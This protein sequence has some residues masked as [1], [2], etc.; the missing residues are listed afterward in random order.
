MQFLHFLGTRLHKI[1][2]LYNSIY[3]IHVLGNGYMDMCRK[4]W[5]IYYGIH[6]LGLYKWMM[7][8]EGVSVMKVA[9]P[10]HALPILNISN[11]CWFTFDVGQ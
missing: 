5:L 6:S 2:K 9:P 11:F 8:C 10:M 3:L 7:R 4:K 1:L